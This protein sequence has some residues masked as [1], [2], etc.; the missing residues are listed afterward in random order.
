MVAIYAEWVATYPIAVLEDGLS[1][2]D[3]A[4]WK[5][6]NDSLGEKL[7][8]VGD[9]L[10]VTNDEGDDWQVRT[11]LGADQRG[12]GQR[13]FCLSGCHRTMSRRLTKTT[14]GSTA[15]AWPRHGLISDRR[16]T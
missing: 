9:D 11:A 1:E 7:E 2:D 16:P 3:W 14:V 15:R 8:L 5:L 6:L 13:S 4:G 10:F 12:A